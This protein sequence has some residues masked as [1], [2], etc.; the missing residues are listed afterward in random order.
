MA[1]SAAI[2][3]YLSKYEI[4]TTDG[5]SIYTEIGELTD[6]SLP[7]DEVD[8]VE[9]T[10]YQSPNKTRE[11]IA[12]LITPGDSEFTINWI[13]GNATDVLVRGLKV[14]GARRN[15]RVSFPNGVK[16]TFPAYIKGVSPTAPIDDKL[17][18]VISVKKAG[19][20]IWS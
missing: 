11:Y 15:H 10:H 3:G 6:F 18:N 7:Q 12:G 1:T 5:G 19:A 20:E 8:D 14:S 16:V 4:S 2:I 13:P 9:V 17:S